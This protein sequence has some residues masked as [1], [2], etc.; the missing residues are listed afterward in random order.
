MA[1]RRRLFIPTFDDTVKPSR[2]P[3][4]LLELDSLRA[5]GRVGGGGSADGI[6][7]GEMS[8]VALGILRKNRKETKETC[9]A[10]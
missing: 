6:P 7:E 1:A 3:R 2:D 8:L 9:L 5:Q 4:I 10:R